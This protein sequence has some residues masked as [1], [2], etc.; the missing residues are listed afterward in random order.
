MWVYAVSLH[1][2]YAGS[3]TNDPRKA[4]LTIRV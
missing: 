3:T 1:R 4:N 2:Q